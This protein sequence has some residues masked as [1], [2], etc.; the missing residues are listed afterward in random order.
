MYTDEWRKKGIK[1][2]MEERIPVSGLVYYRHI[3]GE[4]DE[5]LGVCVDF[6]DADDFHYELLANDWKRFCDTFLEH[7][8]EKQ[9][10][11]QFLEK[12]DLNTVEGWFAF[13]TALQQENI[14]FKKMAFY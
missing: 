6:E 10:F 4:N 8:D 9:M 14:P 2:R 11:K 1:Y 5:I 12:K 3:N 7:G 13:E